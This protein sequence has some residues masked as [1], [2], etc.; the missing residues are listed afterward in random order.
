MLYYLVIGLL[1]G[2]PEWFKGAVLKTVVRDERTVG[3]NPTS[4]FSHMGRAF[5]YLK[6]FCFIKA[7]VENLI[8][9]RV[10]KLV[11]ALDLGSSG[12]PPWEFDSLHAQT[13]KD[14]DICYYPF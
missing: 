11:D 1:G 14:N 3:S 10:A 5:C 7:I 8:Y 13:K 4:S 6:G 12:L 2:V 9:G